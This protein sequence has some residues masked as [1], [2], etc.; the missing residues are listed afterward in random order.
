MITVAGSEPGLAASAQAGL[1][2][3][4]L[5]A[6]PNIPHPKKIIEALPASP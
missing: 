4:D 2:Q 3:R 6:K 1:T 5:L